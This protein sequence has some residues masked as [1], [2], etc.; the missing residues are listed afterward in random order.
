MFVLCPKCWNELKST[1]ASCPNCGSSVDL[2]SR[3]YERRLIAVLPRSGAERRAQICW[4]L[5]SRGKRS[6]VPVLIGLLHDPDIL[7]RVAALRGLGEIGDES[8]VPELERAAASESLAVRNVAKQV[9]NV[10]G[11]SAAG[12]DHRRA[13]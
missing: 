5:A 10:F 9:L 2:Y 6:A 1:P 4:V 11:V 3:E 12:T 7:V 13:G 8:T